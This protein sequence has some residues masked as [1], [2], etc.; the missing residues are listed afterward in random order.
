MNH[1]VTESYFRSEFTLPKWETKTNLHCVGVVVVQLRLDYVVPDLDVVRL[2]ER[3]SG[4]LLPRLGLLLRYLSIVP[5]HIA[6]NPA[7]C[8]VGLV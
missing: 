2:V 1:E 4:V 3:E 8:S 5:D 7:W 6:H